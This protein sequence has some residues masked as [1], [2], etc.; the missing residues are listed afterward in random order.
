M[1]FLFGNI[2]VTADFD[3]SNFSGVMGLK[4]GQTVS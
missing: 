4:P 1:F 2:E 3:K